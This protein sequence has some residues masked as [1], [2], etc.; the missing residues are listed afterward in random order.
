MSRKLPIEGVA[1]TDFIL[2]CRSGLA[3]IARAMR[4]RYLATLEPKEGEESIVGPSDDD[5]ALTI[6]AGLDKSP[7]S[8]V[9]H[10]LT[11][12]FFAEQNEWDALSQVAEAGLAA[13]G[14]CETEIG[15]TIP[16]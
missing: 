4:Q 15:R 5:L 12:H 2:G 9:A 13:L 11:I 10:L 7:D 3:S 1:Q 16:R 8:I 14:R 6:E